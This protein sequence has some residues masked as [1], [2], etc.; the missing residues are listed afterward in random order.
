VLGVV[1]ALGFWMQ[2]PAPAGAAKT[3]LKQEAASL[4]P[5]PRLVVLRLSASPPSAALYL[6][7]ERLAANPFAAQRSL[8]TSPHRLRVEAAG[9]LA[10][11][12]DLVLDR[13]VELELALSPLA[14]APPAPA[15]LTEAASSPGST[16]SPSVSPAHRA[17]AKPSSRRQREAAHAGTPDATP[18][19]TVPADGKPNLPRKHSLELDRSSPWGKP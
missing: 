9:Y 5:A 2:R 12:R 3:E 6:D 1:V 13:D 8:D 17:A 18:P 4:Q 14:A 19:P 7:G 10:L 15:P 16:H 11:D